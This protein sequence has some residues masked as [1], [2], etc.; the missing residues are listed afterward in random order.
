LRLAILFSGGKD[1]SYTIMKAKEKN[2]DVCLLFTLNPR[3][4]KSWLFHHPFIQWTR[5]QAEA[6]NL[7]IMTY[8]VESEGEGERD[9]LERHLKD[10]KSRFGIEGIASGAIASQYQKK[11]IERTASNLGLEIFTPLWGRE[12]LELLRDQVRSG[13]DIRIIAVAALGLDQE[14]LGRRL[15][16]DAAGELSQLNRKYGVNPS[17]EGGE[18]ETFVVDSPLFRRRITFRNQRKVWLGDG[19]H[20]EIEMA[21]LINKE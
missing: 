20:L 19:G 18:Y 15:D 17:G 4:S 13:L 11:R 5:L 8:D 16:E 2:L 10:I 1:S 7:P 9:E 6:M 3:S 21:E 12:P 14:W